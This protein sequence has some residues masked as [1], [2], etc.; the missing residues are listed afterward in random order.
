VIKPRKILVD[1]TAAALHLRKAFGVTISP[2]TIRSWA[3]RGKIQRWNADQP[4]PHYDLRE[5]QEYF[6]R[7]A[8]SR[9]LAS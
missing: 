3:Q 8:D 1:A 7:R 4:G 6:Q 9:R 5:V 2:V